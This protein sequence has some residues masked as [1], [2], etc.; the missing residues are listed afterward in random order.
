MAP[1]SR[2]PERSIGRGLTGKGRKLVELL[3]AYGALKEGFRLVVLK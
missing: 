3:T 1:P 2:R